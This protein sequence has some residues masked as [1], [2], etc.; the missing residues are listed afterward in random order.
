MLPVLPV[1][2]TM[3]ILITLPTPSTLLEFSELPLLLSEVLVNEPGSATSLEFIELVAQHPVQEGFALLVAND[4]TIGVPGA[5]LDSGS[6]LVVCRDR[7]RFEAH[8]GDSTGVWGD[9]VAEDYTLQEADM[10]LPNGEGFVSLLQLQQ[11]DRFEWNGDAS[12]GTSYERVADSHWQPTDPSVGCTP[13]RR[14]SGWPAD[15]DWSLEQMHMPR[16][17][18]RSG[19]PTR[20]TIQIRN[21]GMLASDGVLGVVLEPHDTLQP[22]VFSG[23]PGVH[24]ELYTDLLPQPGLNV[25]EVA[26]SHDDRLTNNSGQL[27]FYADSGPLVFSELYPA[28][29]AGQ[30]E[31]VELSATANHA[32]GL[33]AVSITD[34]HDT[35]QVAPEFWLTSDYDYVVITSDSFLFR[36]AYPGAVV[37]LIQPRGWASLNNDGDTLELLLQGAGIDRAAYP[38]PGSRRGVAYE[39]IGTSE[40]WGWSVSESGATPGAVNSIDVPYID[41]IQVDVQPNPFAAGDGE[42][43]SFQ[44]RVPFGAQAELRLFSGDGRLVRTLFERKSV[45]SG[46]THWD[47]Q[48]D[49]GVPVSVGIYVLQFRLFEPQ[50]QVYLGTVVVA[51]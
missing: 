46:Q 4:D 3:P 47:G 7:E 17:V 23:A 42:R 51:R 34:G 33:L 15:L 9:G 27:A 29:V 45:V 2:A 10:S 40:V 35:A 20:L 12:D 38:S 26:L 1:L 8:F 36:L 50:D 21:S 43:A 31:W 13:G 14:N 19:E 37:P 49:N 25:V 44:Y 28:P 32:S 30:P 18:L 39:R 16:G 22:L 5:P 48:G 24:V 6:Y 41:G 11:E